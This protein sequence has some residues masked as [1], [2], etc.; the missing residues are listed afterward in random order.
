M[1]EKISNITRLY[2]ILI[3]ILL[4]FTGLVLLIFFFLIITVPFGL[5]ALAWAGIF[6]YLAIAGRPYSDFKAS[7][8]EYPLPRRFRAKRE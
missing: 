5:A 1:Y 6:V 3:A 2:Y 4:F 7:L 8:K